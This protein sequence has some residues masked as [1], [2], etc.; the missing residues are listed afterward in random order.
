[1]YIIKRTKMSE[2]SFGQI[3]WKLAIFR[4][5]AQVNQEHAEDYF[6]TTEY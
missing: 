6:L 3:N 2:L 5:K 1:M 4:T